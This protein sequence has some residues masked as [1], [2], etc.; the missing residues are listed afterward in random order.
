[1]TQ[2][3][4]DEPASVLL[5]RLRA[6]KEAMVKAGKLKR[7]KNPS[8]IFRGADNLPYEKIGDRES[9]CIADEV[10]FNFP[11][12]WEIARL[13]TVCQ[14]VDGERTL[15]ALYPVLDAKFLRAKG[16]VSFSENGKFVSKGTKVILVDGENSGEVF[17]A[18]Q[19]GYMGSTF[20]ILWLSSEVYAPYIL[21]FIEFYRIPLKN[22]KRGAAIPHLDKAMF[23]H[24]LLPL[25]PLAEQKRIVEAINKLTPHL[26][27]YNRIETELS[28]LDS[29]FPEQLKKSILQQAVQG[30]LV[31]QDPNDEPASALLARIR[32]EK[33]RL[34]REGKIK[35]DKHE[36]I[37]YRRD[38]S[39][40]EKANGLER[41]IDDEI[42]FEIPSSWEWVRFKDLIQIIA[43]TSYK[44]TDVT[45]QGI[46]ILRG[47]NIQNYRLVLRDDDVYLNYKY[48]DKKKN[49]IVGDV[50]FVA[51]TGSKEVIGKPAFIESAHENT[52]IGAFLRI[53]RPLYEFMKPYIWFIFGSAYYRKHIRNRAQGTN[54][55]NIKSEYIEELLIP[56]PP[57]S[58]QKRIVA[59]IDGLQ[60]AFNGL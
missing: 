55:N 47:G 45:N 1:M 34:I 10:P 43:G 33:K 25:P 26:E 52:Q 6:E 51:S 17:T 53:A 27:N 3:A 42:P 39:H 19:D 28:E 54:I 32:T 35:R 59:K 48:C 37:I 30:K 57:I 31:P 21:N 2:N 12:S 49:I 60:S 4:D 29:N 58:E 36:S 15:G 50:I 22:S 44:K 24:L 13:S 8:F 46:R 9:V 41:C 23:Y 16:D 40:Y 11:N 18:P 5:K 56:I 20:K 38:N 7:E 14:L